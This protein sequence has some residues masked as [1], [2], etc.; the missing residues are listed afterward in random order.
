VSLLSLDVVP[1]EEKDDSAA[2]SLLSS[3]AMPREEDNSDVLVS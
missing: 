1:R 2:V 3:D